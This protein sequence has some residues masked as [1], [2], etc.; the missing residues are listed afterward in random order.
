MVGTT[1][2]RVPRARHDAGLEPVDW[3]RVVL[4]IVVVLLA[5]AAGVLAAGR[6]GRGPAAVYFVSAEPTA[7]ATELK[8]AA[9]TLAASSRWTRAAHSG[10]P[11]TNPV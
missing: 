8:P 1:A 11:Y 7:S 4:V 2:T 5:V 9:L 10:P 3:F 6:L